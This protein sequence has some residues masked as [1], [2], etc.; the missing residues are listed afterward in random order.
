MKLDDLINQTSEWLRGTGP[1][2]DIVIS[3][4]IRLARNISKLPFSHR[5]LKAQ[6][7]QALKICRNAIESSDFMKG[8]IF[9]KIDEL[10]SIDKQFLLERHLV[11]KELIA[12]S[13]SK[14][15]VISE[16]EI[17][18]IMINEED[19][20]RIQVVQSGF[21]LSQAWQIIDKIDAELGSKID[22][23][24]SHDLGFL[25]AC[26]TNTGTGMRAS[27]ML[28]LPALVITKQINRLLQTISKL[29]L[30]A[31]GF[32]GEGTQASGNF[33]QISNQTT[34]GHTEFDVIDNIER[35]VR[36]IVTHEQNA[37][38]I[39]NAQHKIE[40][41]D[42]IYRALGTL[43]SAHIITSNETIEL[44]SMVRLGMDM[45]FVKNIIMSKLNQL[46]IFTQPAHL[47][48]LEG[49]ALSPTER[50]VKRAEVIREAIGK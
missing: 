46:F 15:V 8:S 31:R 37:R 27:V 24:F 49:K 38:K 21:N 19:H 5:A 11:S 48:K 2:S 25:T 33:F 34:L 20:L 3:S 42:R 30:T 50:D 36:Q 14:A 28:H 45:G 23:A 22:F 44:L 7:Q 18:S 9:M 16:K 12:K 10:N 40:F 26:P 35:M 13:D 6:S 4:R 47:Q 17:I 32:Y 1:Q 43:K 41:Q 39:L 29:G